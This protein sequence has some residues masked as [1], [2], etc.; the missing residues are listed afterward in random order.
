[1]KKLISLI[2][3]LMMLCALMP[4]AGAEEAAQPATE[5]WASEESPTGYYVTFRY[6]APEAADVKLSG[7]F[8]F[9]DPMRADPYAGGQGGTEWHDGWVQM[10]DTNGWALIDMEKDEAGVWSATLALPNGWYNYNFN[11]YDE[12]GELASKTW[13]PSNIPSRLSYEQAEGETWVGDEYL[14]G[15]YVP[16]DPEKVSRDQT[17]MAPNEQAGQVSYGTTTMEDGTV[18][19]YGLYIPYGL[20][21]EREEPYK[22]LILSHGGGGWEG[23]WFNQG[24][25][26]TILDNM[27]ASGD[28]EPTIV[29]TPNATDI[30]FNEVIYADWLNNYMFPYLAENCNASLEPADHAM[31]GLSA[32]SGLTAKLFIN[33]PEMFSYYCLMSNGNLRYGGDRRIP[34][35][36]TEVDVSSEA[37]HAANITI[38]TG[39]YD[40][41]GF[42]GFIDNLRFLNEQGLAHY[43]YYIPGAHTWNF[44]ENALYFFGTNILWK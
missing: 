37:H 20:D 7:E 31:A 6:A 38:A 41:L 40:G 10:Y 17:F 32:G 13:D 14:S 11:I 16:L 9:V 44:W 1:M 35:G 36:A 8:K 26:A 24:T 43:N 33:Y 15:I 25:A 4:L 18:I 29:V 42:D 23:G 39:M 2:L 21:V 3:S 19:T 28:L 34:E 30:S 27:I 22:V 5:V 12:A